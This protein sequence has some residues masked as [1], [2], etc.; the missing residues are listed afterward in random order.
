MWLLNLLSL[1]WLTGFLLWF[2][3]SSFLWPLN[4]VDIVLDFSYIIFV[5][6]VKTRRNVC[7]RGSAGLV[8]CLQ[9]SHIL[10]TSLY[11]QAVKFGN[12]LWALSFTFSAIWLKLACIAFYIKILNDWDSV[13]SHFCPVFEHLI[14]N[15]TSEVF[16]HVP[17][18]DDSNLITVSEVWK[19]SL[20][21]LSQFWMP[22]ILCLCIISVLIGDQTLHI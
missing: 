8:V 20:L 17:F 14:V 11:L 2:L 13:K 6:I 3:P 16:F 21:I 15:V 10:F 1:H 7:R 9:F 22:V 5:V 4:R 18:L 12:A 19:F